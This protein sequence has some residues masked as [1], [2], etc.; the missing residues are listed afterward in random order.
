MDLRLSAKAEYGLKAMIDIA[1]Q[2]GDKPVQVIDIA[3]RQDISRESIAVLMVDLKRAGLVSSVRGP[4]GGYL[5]TRDSSEIS[6][7]QII[8]A[9]EGPIE[10][11]LKQ[12]RP[13]QGTAAAI[14][15]T[16][17]NCLTILVNSLDETSLETLAKMSSSPSSINSRVHSSDSKVPDGYAFNI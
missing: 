8:E 4:S 5:L 12:K 11:V 2:P 3:K 15:E 1:T 14:H 9:L 6:A 16:W 7:K 10:V 13:R 17:H